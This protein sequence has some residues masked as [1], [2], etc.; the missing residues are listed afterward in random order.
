ML[1][2][3]SGK[4]VVAAHRSHINFCVVDST[5]EAQAAYELDRNENVAA[6]VK[7]D[8]LGFALTYIFEGAFRKYYPDYLIRLANETMLVA[9]IKGQDT[10][11]DETKRKYLD[12]WTTAVNSQGGFGQWEWRACLDPS[13]LPS[14]I[15]TASARD[16]SSAK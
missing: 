5:W 7:N 3:F 14:I 13:E 4:P 2:W 8:H 10:T 12:E 15:H 1:P 11:K 9:E 6:W 16:N